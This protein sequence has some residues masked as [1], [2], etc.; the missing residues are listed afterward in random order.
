MSGSEMSIMK[1]DIQADAFLPLYLN[2]TY[3][4]AHRTILH[5]IKYFF[6]Y[7]YWSRMD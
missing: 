1:Q 6:V 3:Y 7:W 4:T 5:S 2:C